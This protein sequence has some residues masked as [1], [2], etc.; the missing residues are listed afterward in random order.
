VSRPD[1]TIVA[2]VLDGDRKAFRE[3]VARYQDQMIALAKVGAVVNRHIAGDDLTEKY[4]AAE[5]AV[6]SEA[7]EQERLRRI[8]RRA[9]R[10]TEKAAVAEKIDASHAEAERQRGEIRDILGRTVLATGTVRFFEPEQIARKTLL[11]TAE[12]AWR[13]SGRTGRAFAIVGLWLVAYLPFWGGG[14]ALFLLGRR[15]WR[16]R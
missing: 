2:D 6:E 3:L 13:S 1:S 15:L 4:V 9:H 11:P 5:R 12:R 10:S 16:R 14:L 8:D 7:Q